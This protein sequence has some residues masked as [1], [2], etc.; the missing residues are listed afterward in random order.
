MI[1]P[2]GVDQGIRG[3]LAQLHGTCWEASW[4]GAHA[5]RL[6][7]AL[8]FMHSQL[9]G[10]RRFHI[11]GYNIPCDYSD[12]D[13]KARACLSF[14]LTVNELAPQ[15]LLAWMRH[16]TLHTCYNLVFL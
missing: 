4:T 1:V 2:S 10:R 11:L 7:F 15:Q 5:G 6:L 14:M 8:A 13:F 16:C 9:L 12:A 3:S